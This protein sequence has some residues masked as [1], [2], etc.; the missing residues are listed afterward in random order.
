MN[1]ES[2]SSLA[3]SRRDEQLREAALI[4]STRSNAKAH[5]IRKLAARAMRATGRACLLLGDALAGSV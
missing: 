2:I 5:P 4:R 1:I 3:R